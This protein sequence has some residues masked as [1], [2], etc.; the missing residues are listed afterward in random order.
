MPGLITAGSCWQFGRFFPKPISHV[1]FSIPDHFIIEAPADSK[2]EFKKYIFIGNPFVSKQKAQS[3][4][5]FGSPYECTD[6]KFINAFIRVEVVF[7][8]HANGA[9]IFYEI[10]IAVEAKGGGKS[11]FKRCSHISEKQWYRA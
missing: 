5:T 7:C 4:R 1:K 8:T 3:G 11:V 6:M 10:K 2:A 9:Y